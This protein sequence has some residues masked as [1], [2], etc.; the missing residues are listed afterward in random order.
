M[1]EL[2]NVWLCK[3]WVTSASSFAPHQGSD[4]FCCGTEHRLG[5][6]GYGTR[7]DY[8]DARVS[9]RRD[10]CPPRAMPGSGCSRPAVEVYIHPQ[11]WPP[12][13]FCYHR[14]N[15]STE[16][17]MLWLTTCIQGWLW[18]LTWSSVGESDREAG[19]VG[20]VETL[21]QWLALSP[22]GV[23]ERHLAQFCVV[24]ERLPREDFFQSNSSCHLCEV[25]GL[26]QMTSFILPQTSVTLQQN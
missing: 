20:V 21:R 4:G 13:S 11:R 18:N 5:K 8:F 2:W 6:R 9:K 1:W 22:W 15:T 16:S 10:I 25:R 12:C 14:L 7:G 3:R 26:D 17:H 19:T 24:Q 23:R